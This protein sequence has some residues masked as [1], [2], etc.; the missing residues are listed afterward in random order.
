LETVGVRAKCD[1][2]LF[3]FGYRADEERCEVPGNPGLAAADGFGFL[4]DFS[5]WDLSEM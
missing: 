5:R 3:G 1:G 2:Q 4:L